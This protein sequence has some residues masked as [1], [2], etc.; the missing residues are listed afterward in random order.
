MLSLVLATSFGAACIATGSAGAADPAPAGERAEITLNVPGDAVVQFDGVE[1]RLLGTTRRFETPSLTPG[2]K[3]GYDVSVTWTEGIQTVVRKR[4]IT[5]RAGGRVT[6]N[7][8][9]SV[10]EGDGGDMLEDPAAPNP[11]GT[12]YN[13]NPLNWP[14][15]PRLPGS[16]SSSPSGLSTQAGI[17]VLVPADAEVFFDGKRTT[18]KGAERLFITPP[19]QSGK[20]YHYDLLARWKEDGKTV[21]QKRRIDVSSGTAIRVD[22]RTPPPKGKTKSSE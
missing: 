14:V 10:L 12:A 18:Q 16:G 13:E 21:E 7:F 1:M 4:H 5:F 15:Y 8:G 9:P 22:M 11:S 2:R 6:L 19:L 20:K 3:Y 17:R